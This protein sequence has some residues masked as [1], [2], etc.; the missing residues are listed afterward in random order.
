MKTL[1]FFLLCGVS[2]GQSTWEVLLPKQDKPIFKELLN[3]QSRQTTLSFQEMKSQMHYMLYT[4]PGTDRTLTNYQVSLTISSSSTWHCLCCDNQKTFDLST[5]L[6]KESYNFKEGL[7]KYLE[8]KNLY[9]PNRIIEDVGL[10]DRHI[11]EW[12]KE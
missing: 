2:W 6:F 7:N 4:P 3:I 10:E 1:L 9:F 8:L 12:R 5:V 11:K